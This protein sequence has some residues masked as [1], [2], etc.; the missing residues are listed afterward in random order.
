MQ[1]NIEEL[2]KIGKYTKENDLGFS[3]NPVISPYELSLWT[4]KNN[5]F[6]SA[7]KHLKNN[8]PFTKD[9]QGYSTYVDLI[10]DLKTWSKREKILQKKDHI[11]S[12]IFLKRFYETL[13]QKN[14]DVQKAT[15]TRNAMTFFNEKFYTE[16][17]IQQFQSLSDYY[18][19]L[20]NSSLIEN[21]SIKFFISMHIYYSIFI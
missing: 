4:L 13:I 6:K 21:N 17:L 7:I 11:K 12:E 15:E 10:K 1:I 9:D 18:V 2:P 8:N 16:Q 5:Q 14:I 20:L 3:L 19:K